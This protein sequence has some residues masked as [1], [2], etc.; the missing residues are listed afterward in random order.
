MNQLALKFPDNTSEILEKDSNIF[1]N[2]EASIFGPTITPANIINNLIPIIF[3][4]AGIILLFML[5]A[6]GFTIFT[7][8]GNPEKIKK[9]TG[10]ITSAVI[11]LLI[12]F[13]AYWII[14]LLQITLGVKL[15]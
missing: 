11:G 4:L 3:V 5:I 10:T 13:A 1:P 14:E 7:S 12:I 6:G 9:G 8:A 15:L 2:A